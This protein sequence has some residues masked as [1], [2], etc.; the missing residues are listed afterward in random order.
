MRENHQIE[1]LTVMEA[2]SQHHGRVVWKSGEAAIKPSV[3][4]IVEFR[5]SLDVE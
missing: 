5:L 1:I 2:G 4:T 3:R